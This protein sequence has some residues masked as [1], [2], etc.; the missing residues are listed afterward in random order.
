M[1]ITST[2]THFRNKRV[3][4]TGGTGF[5]GANLAHALVK[6][7]ARLHMI[8]RSD[9]HF[10]RIE[11]F[12]SHVTLHALDL[13]AP[14]GLE[15]IVADVGPEIVFHLASNSNHH[16]SRI[17]ER[18]EALDT[19]VRGTA[20]VLEALSDDSCSRIVYAGSSMEYGRMD[21]PMKETDPSEPVGFRGLLKLMSTNICD[22][23]ARAEM[24]PVVDLRL[25]SVYGFWEDPARFIPKAIRAALTGE[26]LPLT[27]PG[28]MHDFVFVQDV[29][30]ALLMAAVADGVVGETINIGTGVQH[31]NEEVLDIVEE[32]TGRPVRRAV[33]GYQT[34]SADLKNW[35]ADTAKAREL[36][37][38][39]ARHTLTSGLR[40]TVTWFSEYYGWRLS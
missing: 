9:S 16:P 11:D 18:L 8:V 5:V 1:D 34:K 7:G 30:E 38:W 37:G 28:Y 29:V 14:E 12:S 31:A 25:F 13:S 39:K 23:Y 21:G 4:L 26:E 27:P 20:A 24:R 22:Y 33:G 35:V 15:G 17:R 6:T 36:L 3:L 2:H 19:N 10:W 40:E 32:V